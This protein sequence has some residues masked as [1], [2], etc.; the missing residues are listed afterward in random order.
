METRKS[1]ST[2]SIGEVAA[3]TGLAV[4]AV[5]YYEDEGLITALRSPGG[6]RRFLRAEIRKVSFIAISQRLGF[7]LAEIRDQLQAL[8][9][10]RAP[11][12]ADWA[13]I[14]R[15][16]SVAIDERIARL[17]RLR[18]RLDGCIGCG[19]LSLENCALYNPGD[20]AARFGTGP[21][22]VERQALPEDAPPKSKPY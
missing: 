6:R 10:D 16:F 4:S 8:P 12:R 14:S 7:T 15:S 2:L 13:R 9:G 17:Q 5:R 21:Q 3:R 1:V 22:L 19:C 11:T 20:R 18:N